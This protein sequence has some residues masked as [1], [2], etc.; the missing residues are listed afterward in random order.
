MAYGARLESVLG[1]SPRGFESP[2]LRQVKSAGPWKP[3]RL[4]SRPVSEPTN[5]SRYR[6]ALETL[7]VDLPNR[8]RA[9]QLPGKRADLP[10]SP[11]DGDP[12]EGQS[13]YTL[14]SDGKVPNTDAEDKG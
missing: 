8:P 14:L 4:T 7:F 10:D 6:T 1:A 9:E 11:L 12:L 5:G 2:I 3:S 13:N